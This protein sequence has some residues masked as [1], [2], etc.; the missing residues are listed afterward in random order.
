MEEN[1]YKAPVEFETPTVPTPEYDSPITWHNWFALAVVLGI[2]AKIVAD[3]V[4]GAVH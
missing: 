4:T 3:A 1:P 2:L